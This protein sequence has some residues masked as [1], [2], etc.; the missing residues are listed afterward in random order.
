MFLMPFSA[1]SYT[2]TIYI[3]TLFQACIAQWSFT[4][5]ALYFRFCRL[6]KLGKQGENKQQPGRSGPHRTGWGVNARSPPS[7]LTHTLSCYFSE[8]VTEC[9]DTTVHTEV[10]ICTT[11]SAG[12]VKNPFF[13]FL[14]FLMVLS[15]V[16]GFRTPYHH[17]CARA[18]HIP[19]HQTV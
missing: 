4:S 3:S 19:H 15:K 9:D 5:L 11:Q 16:L 1:F 7:T 8:C 10:C 14:V 2:S 6:E 18:A 13:L 17:H 12:S